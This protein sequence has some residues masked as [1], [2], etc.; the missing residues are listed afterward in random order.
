MYG[1]LLPAFFRVILLRLTISGDLQNIDRRRFIPTGFIRTNGRNTSENSS[2][3]LI[4]FSPDSNLFRHLNFAVGE[5]RDLYLIIVY[6]L[7]S[8]QPTDQKET[9]Q[10]T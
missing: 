3:D 6:R 8:L 7:V 4:S 1:Q 5:D 10:K 9:D 2:F